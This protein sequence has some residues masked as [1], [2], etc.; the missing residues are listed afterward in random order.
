MLS[1]G[2]DIVSKFDKD[3]DYKGATDNLSSIFEKYP[4]YKEFKEEYDRI[5]EQ[6]KHYLLCLE[7]NVVKY[8]RKF[9]NLFAKL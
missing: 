7:R 9:F 2:I 5:F 6:K 1:R 4:A 3:F 8:F